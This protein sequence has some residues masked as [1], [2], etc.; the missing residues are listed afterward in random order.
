[1]LPLAPDRWTTLVVPIAA[2]D[3]P[4][5]V[6]LRARRPFLGTDGRL[7]GA[8]ATRPV[9]VDHVPERSS[10]APSVPITRS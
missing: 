10:R 1:V 4:V 8:R 5:T 3:G 6:A 2:I 7:L 9:L